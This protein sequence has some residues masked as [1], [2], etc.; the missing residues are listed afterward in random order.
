MALTVSA[1]ARFSGPSTETLIK[2]AATCAAVGIAAS[3][4]EYVDYGRWLTVIGVLLLVAGLHRYGRLGPDE[5][6]IFE[7]SPPAKK[8][9]RKTKKPAAS[10][11]EGEGGPPAAAG[12]T[13]P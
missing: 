10:P 8:K 5:A 7:L 3:I 12:E 1:R 2:G 9:K 11:S 13:E 6:I 4:T